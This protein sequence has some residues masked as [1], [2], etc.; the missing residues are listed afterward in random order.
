MY[1]LPLLVV[2]ACNDVVTYNDNYDDQLTNNGP[3][4]IEKIT[5]YNDFASSIDQGYL[6]Q[7]IT[8]HGNNL[9]EVTSIKFNDVNVDLST[10]Y[11]VRGSVTV[12]IPRILP[13]SVNDS[14]EIVT[15][16]G[17]INY[18]F[19][20]TIPTLEIE[21]FYNEFTLPGDTALVLGSN[22]DLYQINKEVG[23]FQLNG[24]DVEVINFSANSFKVVIPEGTPNNSVLKISSPILTSP[25]EVRFRAVD[26]QIL[27]YDNL[28]VDNKMT[29]DF[30]MI[31][32]GTKAGDPKPL[33]RKFSRVQGTFAAFAWKNPIV[34]YVILTNSDIVNNPDNYYVKFEINNKSQ[35]PLSNGN[36]NI[37]GT[38][39]GALA[40]SWNPGANGISLNTYGKWKTV[41]FEAKQLF[42]SNATG[43]CSLILGQNR[44]FVIYQPTVASTVDFSFCNFRFV[45][46]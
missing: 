44:F 45:K 30:T 27:N 36:I 37:G 6:T 22:F 31:T 28:S 16:K 23:E 43:G 7:L 35:Y 21:G 24:M 12:P 42:K 1:V 14:V 3:P 10:I 29:A 32:D 46:K 39:S 25:K 20:V 8:I 34:A 26:F 4:E 15:K 33:I 41:T 9:A 17:K 19:K 18:L 11:A 5:P 13:K 40:F 2:V 38:S